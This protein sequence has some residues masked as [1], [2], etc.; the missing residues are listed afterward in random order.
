MALLSLSLASASGI[1]YTR[2]LAPSTV[3]LGLASQGKGRWRFGAWEIAM[4]DNFKNSLVW[5]PST[6]GSLYHSLVGL[7]Y[8]GRLNDL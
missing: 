5:E 3:L 1:W 6:T 2:T 4:A 7:E 8:T